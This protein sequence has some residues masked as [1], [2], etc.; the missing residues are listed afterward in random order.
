[1]TTYNHQKYIGQAIQSVLAQTF[2]NFEFIIVNDGSTDNTD[3]II[4]SY[5][6]D[7]RIKYIYQDN[8]G[9]SLA[10]NQG[11]VNSRGKYIALMSGDDVCYDQRLEKQYHYLQE[12]NFKVVFSWVNIINEKGNFSKK[13]EAKANVFN[14]NKTRAEILNYFFFKG[15]CFCA[16]TAFIERESILKAGLFNL[17]SIQLQDFDMW[18]KL[19]KDN[20]FSILPQ[21]LLMY[22]I[23]G[24]TDNLSSSVNVLRVNFE[25][26]QVYKCMFENVCIDLFKNAFCKSI[27]RSNF[28]DGIEYDIEKAF[29]YL[30]HEIPFVRSIGVEKL[31]DLLQNQCV[32]FVAKEKYNFR[33]AS[34]YDL[35]QNRNMVNVRQFVDIKRD[36]YWSLC[37][38][39]SSLINIFKGTIL[40]W[41]GLFFKP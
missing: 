8:Q 10:C 5:L 41:Y 21:K 3:K 35:T 7:N 40:K 28:Q 32:L 18:I 31:F 14:H 33:L 15:N 19:L 30:K 23:R 36:I 16:V 6:F 22:R 29:L 9:A 1:M 24:N 4:K 39:L 13:H 27:V 34:L 37:K 20:E 25:A 11:I 12:T 17:S 38:K 26:Y 2:T